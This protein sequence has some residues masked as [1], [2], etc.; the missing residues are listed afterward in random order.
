[1]WSVNFFGKC[2]VFLCLLD[3]T[4][5]V[6][7]TTMVSHVRAI[8]IVRWHVMSDTFADDVTENVFIILSG[9]SFGIFKIEVVLSLEPFSPPREHT[10][11]N[12]WR[13]SH[14]SHSFLTT[15]TLCP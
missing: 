10:S 7:D 14:I 4:C 15:S 3:Y 5:T 12:L 2:T 1:M 9:Y 6:T 13:E 8:A 11:L